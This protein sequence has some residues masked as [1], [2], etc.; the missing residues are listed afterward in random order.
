[1]PIIGSTNVLHLL[2]RLVQ[3]RDRDAALRRRR[4]P[5]ENPFEHRVGQSTRVSRPGR[6]RHGPGGLA[7]QLQHLAIVQQEQRLLRD[8]REVTLRACVSGL[9]KSNVRNSEGR[10]WRSIIA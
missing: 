7:G 2:H 4:E 8:G 6:A 9:A 10:F 1:M 3:E 5:A